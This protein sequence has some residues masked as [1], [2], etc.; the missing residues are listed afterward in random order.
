MNIVVS[1]QRKHHGN[2]EGLNT[3]FWTEELAA[4]YYALSDKEVEII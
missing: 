1:H 4:P 2:P 3:G